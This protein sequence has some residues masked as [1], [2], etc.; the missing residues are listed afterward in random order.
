LLALNAAVEAAR[1]G[2]HGRGFSV[3]AEQVHTLAGRSQES[4]TDTTTLIGDS[5]SRVENGSSIAHTTS[6]SLDTIVKNAS[7]VSEIISG[8]SAASREQREAI[9]QISG[10]LTKI[11]QVVQKN[12]EVSDETAA[13]SQQLNSQAEMLQQ[14]VSYFRL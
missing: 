4:A 1:A 5:I 11:S 13:A 2:E 9:M 14:L 6:E 12:T 8:I 3:V 10:G 7:E